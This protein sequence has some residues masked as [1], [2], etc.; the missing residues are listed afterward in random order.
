MPALSV[1]N[2]TQS[3]IEGGKS[4]Q[5]RA[6]F[7][8]LDQTDVEGR[9]KFQP[10]SLRWVRRVISCRSY[11][12]PL[13]ELCHLLRMAETRAGGAYDLLW[14]PMSAQARNVR[15]W[16]REQAPVRR[17][18][19]PEVEVDETCVRAHYRDG[20]FEISYHRAADLIALAE[21]LVTALGFAELDDARARLTAGGD[22]GQPAAEAANALSRALYAYLGEHLPSVQ[23]GRLTRHLVD[24]LAESGGELDSETVDDETILAFWEAKSGEEGLRSYVA[25]V[26]LVLRTVQ[27]ID[28]AATQRA[29]ATSKTIG[30][31]V[32]ANEV[33]PGDVETLVAAVEPDDDPLVQL[34]TPPADDAKPLNTKE[35]ER[36]AWPAAFGPRAPRLLHS[37]LRAQT[38]GAWQARLAQRNRIDPATLDTLLDQGPEAD[39]AAQLAE[40]QALASHIDRVRLAALAVLLRAQHPGA[41]DYLLRLVPAEALA[42]LAGSP[43]APEPTPEAPG[44]DGPDPY[45]D[46]EAIVQT[47]L[48]G[49][50]DGPTGHPELDRLT[51]DAAKALRGFA[52]QGFKPPYAGDALSAAAAPL[53]RLAD[54]LA[55]IQAAA[56]RPG[57]DWQDRYDRDRA[58]FARAL[59]RLYSG[60]PA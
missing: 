10:S 30:A 40:F 8:L 22:S 13:H 11:A 20:R 32:E 53:D 47:L 4:A 12:P 19:Q 9:A 24:W 35:R 60:A 41:L 58:R 57:I 34:T 43:P 56:E 49:L 37:V 46:R 29:L 50:N 42:P 55:R 39:Y 6:H 14:T 48:T 52:R 17:P 26:R 59:G 21:F 38:F 54:L 15:A 28:A 33:D 31:D 27:L 7:D 2:L 25:C 1:R 36:L 18:G 3:V 51:A 23:E 45:S 5:L 16:F 44:S